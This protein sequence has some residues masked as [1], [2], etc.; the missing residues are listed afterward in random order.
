MSNTQLL[1][2]LPLYIVGTKT[3]TNPVIYSYFSTVPSSE[4]LFVLKSLQQHR[5]KGATRLQS[6]MDSKQICLY[7]VCSIIINTHQK[8]LPN[9]LMSV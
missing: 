1:P 3:R 8:L 9:S 4:R 7:L 2:H 6:V 5:K